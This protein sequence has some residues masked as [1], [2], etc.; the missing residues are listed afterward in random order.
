M[1]TVTDQ[2]ITRLLP[3]AIGLVVDHLD[4]DDHTVTA[5]LRTTAPTACCPNCATPAT[6]VHS[7]YTRTL[8]DLPWATLQVHLHLQVRKFV[9]AVRDCPRRIFTERLPTMVAPYARRT[10]R[11][12]DHLRSV[13]VALGGEA[14]SRLSVRSRMPVSPATLLRLLRRTP[15][16]PP[17]TFKG[18]SE[19]R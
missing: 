13:A 10:L 15:P 1:P 17:P 6:R 2:F 5:L 14:G 7:R 9:C 4:A 3:P 11:Q 18:R 8:V 16:G 19:E 12:A